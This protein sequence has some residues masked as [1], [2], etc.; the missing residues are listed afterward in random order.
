MA[1]IFTLKIDKDELMM[2]IRGLDIYESEGYTDRRHDDVTALRDQLQHFI[3]KE[4][5]WR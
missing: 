2:L 5:P 3:G 4:N 1:D